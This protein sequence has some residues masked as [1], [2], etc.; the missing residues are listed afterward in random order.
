MKNLII[1]LLAICMSASAFAKKD[2][3]PQISEVFVTDTQVVILGSN[4]AEPEVSLGNAGPLVLAQP[5][6]G[7]H[8]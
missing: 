6:A 2:K 8:T 4:F 3:D 1:V 7:D 5:L